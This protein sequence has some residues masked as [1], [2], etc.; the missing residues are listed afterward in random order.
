[1]RDGDSS[2]SAATSRVDKLSR[3]VSSRIESRSTA[4]ASSSARSARARALTARRTVAR[5][6]A[7]RW[8]TG[9]SSACSAVFTHNESASRIRFIAWA[10]ERPWVCAPGTAGTE[11]THQPR[12]SR[13]SSTRYVEAIAPP[14]TVPSPAGSSRAVRDRVPRPHEPG[15]SFGT[16]RTERL[17]VIASGESFGN[18]SASARSG[19]ALAQS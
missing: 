11:A 1:M 2:R 13:S 16:E 6:E 12:S 3:R 4:A 17:R 8:T 9:T 15:S 19:E 5:A 7:G 14:D 18:R 10:I